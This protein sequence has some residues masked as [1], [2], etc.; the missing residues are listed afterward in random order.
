MYIY[1]LALSLDVTSMVK[2]VLIVHAYRS[3]SCHITRIHPDVGI[4]HSLLDTRDDPP[5]WYPDI[6]RS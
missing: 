3:I 6:Q 1:E 4:E 2:D 5:S